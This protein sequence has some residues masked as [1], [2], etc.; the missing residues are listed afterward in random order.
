MAVVLAAATLQMKKEQMRIGKK[1]KAA[2]AA[3]WACRDPLVSI[4]LTNHRESSHF[5]SDF[6]PRRLVNLPP[7][8]SLCEP[9]N[10]VFDLK[11][12]TKGVNTRESCLL[13]LLASAFDKFV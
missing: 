2:A 4:I 7:P 3:A 5:N 9:L 13:P 10:E 11:A 12:E 8:L 1:C 6:M